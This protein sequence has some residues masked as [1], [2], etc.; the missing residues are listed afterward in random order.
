MYFYDFMYRNRQT[1]QERRLTLAPAFHCSQRNHTL[2]LLNTQ[3][4]ALLSGPLLAGKLLY[5]GAAASSEKSYLILW[6]QISLMIYSCV[7]LLG[8]TLIKTLNSATIQ[9]HTKSYNFC[10]YNFSLFSYLWLFPCS[11]SNHKY[12]C[13]QEA[14]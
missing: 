7:I 4:C 12:F 11:Y 14:M 10:N 13:F 9:F 5:W 6:F 2:Q 1:S 8:L 3:S